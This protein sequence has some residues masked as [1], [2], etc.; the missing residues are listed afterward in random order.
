MFS[1]THAIIHCQHSLARM[2]VYICVQVQHVMIPNE[3]ITLVQYVATI[4]TYRPSC[5]ASGS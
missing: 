4:A 1:V 3:I 2:C 5:V